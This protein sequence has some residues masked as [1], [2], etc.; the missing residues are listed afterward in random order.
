MNI[1]LTA[2]QRGRRRRERERQRD[3]ERCGIHNHIGQSFRSGAKRMTASTPSSHSS[4]SKKLMP[5]MKAS[6]KNWARPY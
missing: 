2:F 6:K 3:R 1:Q 5:P 4:S